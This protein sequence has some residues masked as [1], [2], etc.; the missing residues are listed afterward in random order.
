[1][2]KLI[3]TDYQISKFGNFLLDVISRIAWV[4]QNV[5]NTSELHAVILS[6]VFRDSWQNCQMAIQASVALTL[7][8]IICKSNLNIQGILNHSDL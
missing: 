6:L 8:F 2:S 3:Y 5:F 7:K 1:M 4:I